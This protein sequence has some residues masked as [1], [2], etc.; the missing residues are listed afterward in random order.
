[1]RPSAQTALNKAIGGPMPVFTGHHK[2]HF[3]LLAAARNLL[4]VYE[5][6]D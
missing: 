5:K 3:I 6:F 2:T 4:R 1:M